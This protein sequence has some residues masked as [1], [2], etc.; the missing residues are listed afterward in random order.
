MQ[1]VTARH[2]PKLLRYFFYNL[3]T[4]PDTAYVCLQMF[5]YVVVG[6]LKPYHTENAQNLL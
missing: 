5:I 3:W 4:I 2:R 6:L 1:L